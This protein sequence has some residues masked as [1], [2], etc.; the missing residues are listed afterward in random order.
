MHAGARLQV[1]YT[2]Q[3]AFR[4]EYASNI[5]RGGIFIATEDD[6]EVRDTVEVELA[7]TYCDAHHVFEGEIVHCVTPDMAAAGATPGVAVQFLAPVRELQEQLSEFAGEHASTD[8]R[9]TR[10]G[11][12]AAPRSRARVHATL[13][14]EDDSRME[15][16]TRDVSAT[17]L[18][19]EVDGEPLAVGDT[20]FVTLDHPVTGEKMPIEGRVVRHVES[21]RGDVVAM[22]VELTHTAARRTE[23]ASFLNDVQASEHSRRLG[24]ING[25]IADIGIAELLQMFAASLPRGT[26]CVLGEA[27]TGSIGF[28]SGQLLWAEMDGLHGQPALESM[29]ALQYGHFELETRLVEPLCGADDP[30][31]LEAAVLEALCAID[32][33][34]QQA[35]TEARTEPAAAADASGARIPPGATFEVDADVLEDQRD[36]LSQTELAVLELVQVG[37]TVGKLVEV[38]PEPEIGVFVAIDSLMAR[39]VI[40]LAQ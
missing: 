10:T 8:E 29:L 23:V 37:M 40:V 1:E 18:L 4:A 3:D 6:H 5:S 15:A 26:L 32:E 30:I 36:D 7:L 39:G 2:S 16:K 20:V 17:G 11:R 12:R 33:M 22:G 24:A 28:E 9:V 38:I 25:P 35:N 34:R 19:L 27:A 14:S 21:A 31:S 13:E